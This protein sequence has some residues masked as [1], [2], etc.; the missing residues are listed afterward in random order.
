MND[1]NLLKIG[2]AQIAPFWLNKE[3]TREKIRE[4][5]EKGLAS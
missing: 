1:S 4:Y 3:L 5:M 2:L